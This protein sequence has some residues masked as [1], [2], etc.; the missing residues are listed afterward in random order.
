MPTTADRSNRGSATIRRPRISKE[1][2]QSSAVLLSAVVAPLVGA[3]PIGS[4]ARDVVWSALI[5][6]LAAYLGSTA[7]RGPLIIASIIAL[8]A[9][10]SVGAGAFAIVAVA[11]AS[12]STRHLRHRAFF[13]RG[14]AGGAAAISVLATGATQPAW[15]TGLA[16]FGVG[17]V[18]AVSG[19]RNLERRAQR[20]CRWAA[21]AAF[22][23]VTM[24]SSMA[25]IGVI[26]STRKI[27]VGTAQLELGLSSARHGDAVNAALHLELATAELQG[28]RSSIRRW[29]LPGEVVPLTAQHV[30]AL[31]SV[32]GHVREAA[33]QA[34]ATAQATDMHDLTVES[35]R[36]DV[37]AISQLENP[38]RRL[39]TTLA[40]LV[41]EVHERSGEPL[42]PPL[43]RRL[44]VLGDQAARAQR[45]AALGA[46]G[47]REAPQFLG[48]DAPRRY[49]VLFTSPSEARGRFGFPAS[50]AEVT[51]DRGRFLLGEHGSISALL[52][53]VQPDQ[54]AFDRSDEQLRPY[55]SYGATRQ[56]LSATV[57]PDFP[58]V[59]SVTSTLWAA[60]GRAP[61]DGVL[62]FD[63]AAL[64]SLVAFT[65]PVTVSSVPQPLTALNLEQFLVFGQYVQF[66]T[67]V[68][69][70]REVLQ[71]VADV[72]FERLVTANLPSPRTLIDV[73][74][75]LVHAGHL[76]VVSFDR[77]A[78]PLLDQA[79]LDGTFDAPDDDGLMVSNINTTANKIDSFLTKS[80][81][82]DAHTSQGTLDGSVSVALTNHAPSSGLPSYVIGSATKPP[83]P[84]GT[85]RMTLLVYTGVEG[86]Q[87]LV[88]GQPVAAP[89]ALRTG[90][91]WLHQVTL[92]LPAGATR[93]VRFE[94]HG[95][96]PDPG[97]PYRLRL[98]PGGGST[99][100]QYT[101]GVQAGKRHAAFTGVVPSPLS[102]R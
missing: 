68:A 41:R 77:G 86:D 95:R 44:V 37:K 67:E 21:L 61:V 47:A 32:L 83:L 59:A 81:T 6:G 45:E 76:D 66:P 70:R 26:G 1:N 52:S 58:T 14:L 23:F 38:F 94:L 36:L 90:G 92:D 48:G 15:L 84:S 10:R 82:Y 93:T 57:P 27:D 78:A 13:A 34:I 4:T 22:F 17:A 56:F 51:M 96:L 43:K 64:A 73:F 29:G 33:G 28:A 72:T 3:A 98:Q 5:G 65:G 2:R 16:G 24:A 55:L 54:T 75:P 46:E 31:T 85:N 9:A 60:S 80:V 99:P 11:C 20:W 74:A 97:G 18:I 79:D 49:L 40:S 87:V 101:V 88:D 8:L 91:W 50:F 53:R 63:P 62:R 71:T 30:D 89:P 35:G 19:Y 42:V 12:L 39:S 69:P 7:K 25:L 102:V 100:D